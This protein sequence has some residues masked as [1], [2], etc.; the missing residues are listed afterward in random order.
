MSMTIR[1]VTGQSLVSTDEPTAAA[2]AAAAA[3]VMTCPEMS[4]HTL[5]TA[6][7]QSVERRLSERTCHI[8]QLSII[9]NDSHRHG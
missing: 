9:L 7:D 1:S 5:I 6:T 8:E 2:A 3:A 4:S